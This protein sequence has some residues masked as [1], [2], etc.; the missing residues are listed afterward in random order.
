MPVKEVKESDNFKR[1][2]Q[3]IDKSLKIKL[4]KILLKIIDNP[5]IGKP[6]KYGRKNTREVYMK[7]FGISYSFEYSTLIL[8]FLDLYHKNKQ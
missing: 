6:M 5:E 1:S 2:Y 3:K 7:S 4:D 8:Y